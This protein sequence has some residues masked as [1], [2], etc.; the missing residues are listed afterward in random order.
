VTLLE[1]NQQDKSIVAGELQNDLELTKVQIKI[2]QLRK[3]SRKN[4]TGKYT[5]R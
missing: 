3:S 4:R 5:G 2:N 1:E